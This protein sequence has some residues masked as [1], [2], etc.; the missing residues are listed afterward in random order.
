[1][2]WTPIP[3][4]KA[5]AGWKLALIVAVL[6]ALLLFAI[7][8]QASGATPTPAERTACTPD[9]IR[10]C[11]AHANNRANMIACLQ[12]H[13]AELSAECQAVFRTRKGK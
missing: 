8:Q 4:T 7:S 1:M 3:P 13:R 12:A 5:W 2:I 9:A 6:G 11:M 10:F